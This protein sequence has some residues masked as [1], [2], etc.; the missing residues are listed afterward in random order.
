M[1]KYLYCEQ[2]YFSLRTTLIGESVP[3]FP[4][5]YNTDSPSTPLVDEGLHTFTSLCLPFPLRPWVTVPGKEWDYTR[6]G[7][8]D[9]EKKV[10][11]R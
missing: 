2:G 5:T 10:G 1:N 9:R 7:G 6:V 8:F 11:E 4:N 3:K